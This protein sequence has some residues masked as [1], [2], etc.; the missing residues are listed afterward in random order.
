L[1]AA[2]NLARPPE[3]QSEP[4]ADTGDLKSKRLVFLR[5]V[6]SLDR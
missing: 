6:R 1:T 4:V 2:V 3:G 5:V